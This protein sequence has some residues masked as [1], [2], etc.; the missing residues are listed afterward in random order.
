MACALQNFRKFLQSLED[1]GVDMS[2]LTVSKSY[3]VLVGL[4]AYSKL[5]KGKKKFKGK[6]SKVKENKEKA[7]NK[8]GG[9]GLLG[10]LEKG[11]DTNRSRDGDKEGGSSAGGSGHDEQPHPH[12]HN[13]H[14]LFEKVK[15]WRQ[16]HRRRSTGNSASS[17]GTGTETAPYSSTT[18]GRSVHEGGV[19]GDTVHSHGTAAAAHDPDHG[20]AAEA[21][22]RERAEVCGVEN[23]A[24]VPKVGA[25]GCT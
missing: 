1:L 11:R 20:E 15:E 12:R 22:K 5:V 17:T 14:T 10:L 18:T 21:E 24:R 25:W 19:G 23:G 7:E 3:A 6:T 13:H 9:I 4:E 16:N 2:D 8:Y